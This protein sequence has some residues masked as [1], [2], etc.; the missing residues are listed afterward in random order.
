MYNPYGTIRSWIANALVIHGAA[1]IHPEYT[2][3]YNIITAE[4]HLETMSR[5]EYEQRVDKLINEY[6]PTFLSI[7]AIMFSAILIWLSV[8]VHEPAHIDLCLELARIYFSV[9]Q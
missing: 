7:L 1:R 2:M 5:V 4:D 8:R 3:A 6:G 9:N